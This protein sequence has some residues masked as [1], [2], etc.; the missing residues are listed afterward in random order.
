MRTLLCD[1]IQDNE[2]GLDFSHIKEQKGMFSFLGITSLQLERLRDEFGIYIVSSTRINLAGVNSNNIDY[3]SQSMLR[4][5][6][7]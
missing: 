1:S 2:A 5:L 6:K 4:V 7:P 3:L